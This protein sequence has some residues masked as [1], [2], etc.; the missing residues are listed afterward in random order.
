MSYLSFCIGVIVI[1]I[2]FVVDLVVIKDTSM[3]SLPAAATMSASGFE[4]L[5]CFIFRHSRSI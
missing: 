4:N 5:H 1:V 3:P 2:V